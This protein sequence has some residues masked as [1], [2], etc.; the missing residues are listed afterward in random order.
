M[1]LGE[2]GGL[3]YLLGVKKGG[4]VTGISQGVYPQK[5]H[6]E[7]FCSTFKD[8]EQNKYDTSYVLRKNWYLLGEEKILSHAHK[9]GSW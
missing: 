2:G 4:F 3:S 5:V 6:I 8:I 1:V 7:D 9:T